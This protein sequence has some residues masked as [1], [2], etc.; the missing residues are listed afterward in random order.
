M[1]AWTDFFHV[2]DHFVVD[3]VVAVRLLLVLL[4]CLEDYGDVIRLDIVW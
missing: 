4:D 2:M 1:I 3:H